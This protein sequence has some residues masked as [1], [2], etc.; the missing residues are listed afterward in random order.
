MLLTPHIKRIVIPIHCLAVVCIFLLSTGFFPWQWLVCTLLGWF[1]ISGLGVAIGLHRLL[2]HQAFETSVAIKRF[3]AYLGCLGAQGSPIFWASI[4]RGLHH[5]FS[6]T[7]KDLHSP[8]HGKW[9]AYMGWQMRVEPRD[10]PFRSSMDLAKDPVLKF[11]HKHYY[12]I[13]WGTISFAAA[14]DYRLALTGLVLPMFLSMHLENMVDLFCHLPAFGYRNHDIRDN[15]TNV[16]WLGY[17][18]FGQGWHNNHHARPQ[19]YD[20]GGE[21]WFEI[22]PCRFIVPLLE[23]R[24][25]SRRQDIR[26]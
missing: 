6:D 17:L 12:A 5:P 13:V 24:R 22:D 15:S 3:L 7:E 16:P 2:S 1:C 8:I 14:C 26:S 10:V 25:V 23:R 4:H 19:D 11:L 9:R 20:F 18:D 21:R